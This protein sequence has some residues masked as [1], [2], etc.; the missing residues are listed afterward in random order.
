MACEQQDALINKYSG[1]ELSKRIP[2]EEL[3]NLRVADQSVQHSN[4]NGQD[5]R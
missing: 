4:G 5:L 1:A 3:A 2:T